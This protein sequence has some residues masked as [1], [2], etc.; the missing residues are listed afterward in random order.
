MNAILF[1]EY[2]FLAVLKVDT[3]ALC[4]HRYFR[5]NCSKLRCL[6]VGSGYSFR[7]ISPY[8]RSKKKK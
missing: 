8:F 4:A 6:I 7:H 1:E 5:D 2:K 3:G